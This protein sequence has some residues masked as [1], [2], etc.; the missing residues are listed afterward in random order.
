MAEYQV[1]RQVVAEGQGLTLNTSYPLLIVGVLCH[2]RCTQAIAIDDRP[3]SAA[4]ILVILF[5]LL[6]VII[7]R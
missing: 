7:S 2:A 6:S 5:F 3:V 4:I 1:Q